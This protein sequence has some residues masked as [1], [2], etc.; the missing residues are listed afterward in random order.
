[1][2][3]AAEVTPVM[4]K[5]VLRCSENH[6]DMTEEESIDKPTYGRFLGPN[7]NA[8]TWG[9]LFALAGDS[10]PTEFKDSL[11]MEEKRKDRATRQMDGEVES[12]GSEGTASF[13]YTRK[14]RTLRNRV[15]GLCTRT[16]GRTY[17]DSKPGLPEAV[18]VDWPRTGH[19]SM[20]SFASRILDS[21]GQRRP[22]FEG[23]GDLRV[24]IEQRQRFEKP[25]TTLRSKTLR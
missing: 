23:G 25:V 7:S 2:H 6:S 22:Q 13:I 3:D 11:G 14:L 18:F 19:H 16:G 12:E 17:T 24:V 10:S 20:V 4:Y 5:R 1:M 9:R 8:F 15:A 21:I